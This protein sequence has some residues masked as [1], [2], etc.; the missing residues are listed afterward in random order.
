MNG[1]IVNW[2][3]NYKVHNYFVELLSKYLN[4]INQA[5]TYLLDHTIKRQQACSI[6]TVM[7]MAAILCNL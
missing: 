4:L 1:F 6:V 5:S 3:H 7:A 2:K